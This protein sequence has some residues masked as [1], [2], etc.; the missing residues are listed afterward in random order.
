MMRSLIVLLLPA[1]VQSFTTTISLSDSDSCDLYSSN[2]VWDDSVYLVRWSGK[3]LSSTCSL[4]FNNENTDRKLCIKTQSYSVSSCSLKVKYY[5][6]LL[7]DIPQKSYSCYDYPSEYCGDT[8]NDLT[9]KVDATG[10]SSFGTGGYFTFKVYSKS[11]SH[12]VVIGA[13]VGA[14]IVFGCCVLIVVLIIIRRRRMVPRTSIMTS[15]P[16]AGNT[17]VVTNTNTV[18]TAA[19][20]NNPN[21]PAY[22]Q[23]PPPY[24]QNQ[25]ANQYPANQY[26]GAQ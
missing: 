2:D 24:S 22:P 16:P 11:E 13:S 7:G 5:G 20:Y 9:I 15:Y 19:G 3:K 6:G 25:Y 4:K 10:V 14:S 17:T 18:N 1:L 26:P 23:A 8:Y 12:G 21:Y